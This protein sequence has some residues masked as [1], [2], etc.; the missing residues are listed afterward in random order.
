MFE[1]FTISLP[2]D[3]IHQP[4]K[5]YRSLRLKQCLEETVEAGPEAELEE[6]A[7][8]EDSMISTD[9]SFEN[10]L[11]SQ[12]VFRVPREVC[13]SVSTASDNTDTEY[14]A[15]A[16]ES[17]AEAVGRGVASRHVSNISRDSVSKTFRFRVLD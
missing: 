11:C 13:E 16:L 8:A 9:D 17:S 7:I 15:A 2:A 5:V 14:D 4:E 12:M 3:F 1:R 10:E 6:V